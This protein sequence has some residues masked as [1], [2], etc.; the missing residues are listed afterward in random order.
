MAEALVNYYLQDLWKFK[1]DLLPRWLKCFLKYTL[2]I[3]K[4]TYVENEFVPDLKIDVVDRALLYVDPTAHDIR[5]ATWVIEKFFL[6]TSD[7]LERVEQGWWKLDPELVTTYKGAGD[8]KDDM[9]KRYFGDHYQKRFSIQ[10]DELI[11]C[12]E[13]WQA[14]VKGVGSAY[15]VLVGGITGELACYG[16]NPMPY[17]GLPYRAKAFDPDE[18][19]LDGTSVV[20]Q[21]RPFQE[22]LNTFINYRVTDVRKN[23][24]R[25]VAATGR[26]IDAQTQQDFADGHKI[27]RLSEEVLEASKDPSFDLRKH[28]VELPFG[29]STSELLQQDLPM[30]LGL[31]KES[32]NVSDV[33]RGMAPPHQATLGQ[34][35]EQLS[36][37]QGV[38]RP[39]Y[40]QVMRGIEELAEIIFVYLKDPILFPVERI[41]QIVGKNQYADVV[42]G[43]HNVKGTD[44]NIRS[45]TPDEMDI[46]V[47]INAVSGADAMASRTLLM[48]SL[49]SI[50]QSIGQIPELYKELSGELNFSRIVE[51]ML[52]ATGQD[53]DAL[54]LN[55]QQKQQK[56]QQQAQAQQSAQQ[57]QMQMAQLQIQLE[58]IKE[59]AIQKAKAEAQIAVDSNKNQGQLKLQERQ[60]FLENENMLDQISHKVS[61]QLRADLIRMLKEAQLEM[62][63]NI[64]VGH[65]NNL[66]ESQGFSNK[67]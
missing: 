11:E 5:N 20:E 35:Q 21:Y 10:E 27:V 30:L 23:I 43:W 59:Q 65:G 53:T 16:E 29:T 60:A 48:S 26:F 22:V 50:F 42:Q 54:K 63:N 3:W 28:F 56:A 57:T 15:G 7:V 17:K 46:D 47:T 9:F 67:Q 49:E 37:N 62:F 25:P 32:S 13:Y 44:T 31:G 36:R 19:A 58:A 12:Y 66:N 38:F 40:M 39:V 18:W 34:I 64:S 33:L 41:I 45:V 61:E 52:H 4:V 55:P 8:T 6:N 2:A 51:M 24:I 1:D 14:P